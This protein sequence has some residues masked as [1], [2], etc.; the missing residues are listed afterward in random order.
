L[1]SSDPRVITV[2]SG[3]MLNQKLDA[4]DPQCEKMNPFDGRKVYSQNKRGQIVMTE[5]LAKAFPKVHFSTMHPGWADTPAVRTSMPDFYEKMKS[6][7]RT[8]E[9]GADT[10]VWLAVS[11]AAKSQPSG[12]FFQGKFAS[13]AFQCYLTNY[14]LGKHIKMF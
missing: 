14:F 1:R 2:S 6:R 5:H 3:G 13:N 11:H 10:I 8:A 12:L 4:E 7:L 9:Q